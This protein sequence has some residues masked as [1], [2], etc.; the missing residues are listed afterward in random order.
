MTKQN[1]SDWLEDTL[2]SLGKNTFIK[3]Y[4]LFETHAFD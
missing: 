4:E 1:N 3:Y 2:K